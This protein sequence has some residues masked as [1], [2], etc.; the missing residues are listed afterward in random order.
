MSQN[1]L[2]MKFSIM[3]QAHIR[4]TSNTIEKWVSGILGSMLAQSMII[5]KHVQ[6]LILSALTLVISAPITIQGQALLGK[7]NHQLKISQIR[8]FQTRN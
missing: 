6:G 1:S 3:I 7:P 4:L 2:L 5:A 8:I